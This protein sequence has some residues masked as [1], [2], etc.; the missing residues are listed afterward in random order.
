MALAPAVRAAGPDVI[1]AEVEFPFRWGTVGDITAYSIATVSCN[2]GTQPVLWQA[3]TPNHPVIGQNFYRL[4]DG[5]FE[6]IGMSW[7]KHGFA[8]VNDSGLC[9]TCQNPFNT[10]LLGVGCHD[11]YGAGLNG[12]PSNLGPRSQ[13]NASTGV[14]PYPWTAPPPAATIGRRLQ[15]NNA[16]LDPALNPG[17]IYFMEGHYVTADDAAAGNDENNASYRRMTLTAPS[18]GVYN[19]AHA[20]TT[21]RQK[22]A[23]QAWKDTDASV[24]LV[25]VDIAG[26]GRLIV[27]CKVTDLGGYRWQYEYAVQNLNSHRSV[28]AFSVPISQ[29]TLVPSTGFHDVKHHSGEPYSTEDWATTRAGDE[30]KWACTPYATNENANA[31]R[32][33][34]LFNFRF[35]A[36]SPP[37]PN[38]QVQ[39]E[40]FRPGSPASVI[41]ELPGPSPLPPDCNDNEIEDYLEIQGDPLL[42]CDSNGNLDE[43]D[44]DCDGNNIPDACDIA[45]DPLLDCDSNG[46]LDDCQIDTGSP[47][48][49]GPFYC[50]SGCDPDCNSNG[51]PDGCDIDSG[52]DTDCNSNGVPDQ[53]DIAAMTSEDCNENGLPDECEIAVGSPAPGGPFHCTSGCDPDCNGNGIPDEC[54]IAGGFDGDCDGNEIPD[55]CDIDA[56]PG[57]DCNSNGVIDACGEVDCNENSVPDDCEFPA[58]PGILKGDFDCDGDVDL[59]DVAPFV[60]QVLSGRVSCQADYNGDGAVNGLDVKGFVEALTP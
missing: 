38:A 15:V 33:G 18:P 22:P 3:D 7:L 32:W 56:D 42:D 12:N 36:L 44:I 39:L 29:H 52:F 25:N 30:M 55:S 2:I 51:I 53:C 27:A 41:A 46:V 49:G 45:A 43:C 37:I 28:G 17:A 34:T 23:I 19:F 9:G 20:A 54:D 50:T 24:T 13:V 35:V 5:R 31:L 58:C 6:Q 47:A 1:V 8:S 60:E 16:D 48:P 11:P 59:D 10:Q 4:K 40:L 26:D 57:I 14:F 21:Q